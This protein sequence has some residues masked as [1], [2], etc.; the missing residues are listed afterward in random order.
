MLWM[1]GAALAADCGDD[2]ERAQARL[3]ARKPLAATL[4]AFRLLESGV[5]PDQEGSANLLMGAG[6]LDLDLPHSA[7]HYF[8]QVATNPPSERAAEVALIRLVQIA[9]LTGDDDVL[10]RLVPAIDERDWPEPARDHLH[11]AAGSRAW[12]K[13]ELSEAR[14]HFSLVSPDSEL[15]SRALYSEGV[16][17]VDQGRLK[18][19][20]KEFVRVGRLGYHGDWAALGMGRVYYGIGRYDLAGQWFEQVPVTSDQFAEA[21]FENAWSSF[22]QNDPNRALGELLTL[23]APS[24]TDTVYQPEG[25]LLESIVWYSLCEWENSRTSLD[26]LDAQVQPV[27]EALDAAIR[28]YASDEGRRIAGEAY[29]DW[30]VEDHDTALDK[31]VFLRL[32]QDRSLFSSIEHIGRVQGERELISQQKSLWRDS[33]GVR[34]LERLGRDER[35]LERKA[36]LH[37]LRRMAELDST[38]RN[39]MGQADI[40]RYELLRAEREGLED[41]AGG[42]EVFEASLDPD[43]A[44]DATRVMWPFNGEFW[45][46][47]LGGYVYTEQGACQ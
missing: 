47:E 46:D 9:E 11:Y 44:V 37:L 33:V 28:P 5:C 14:R 45:E 27:H 2:L 16:A 36:G 41:L 7:Q 35:R 31:A 40:V 26:A 4:G 25:P 8:L 12:Q 39:L 32:L 38:L 18:S 13:G 23:K 19:A 3:R 24:Y 17:L 30:F 1:L 21:R 15:G 29:R 42:G 10:M 6:L 34:L 43:Y 20:A 22:M